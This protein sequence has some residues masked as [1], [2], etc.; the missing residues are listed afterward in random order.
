MKQDPW[1]KVEPNSSGTSEGQRE[2]KT[3]GGEIKEAAKDA[4][5]NVSND[6]KEGAKETSSVAKQAAGHAKDNGADALRSAKDA[7]KEVARTAADMGSEAKKGITEV[8]KDAVDGAS[9]IGKAATTAASDAKDGASAIT[10]ATVAAASDAAKGVGDVA[11]AV[12]DE[13]LK[14]AQQAKE[15]VTNAAQRIGPTIQRATRATGAFVASNAVPMSLLGFGAGWLFM[16]SMRSGSKAKSNL[17]PALGSESGLGSEPVLGSD[18]E[19][20]DIEIERPLQTSELE[21]SP[22]H[23]TRARL[24][25]R[26]G[27]IR[28][29]ATDLTHRAEHRIEQAGEAVGRRA[30]KLS[31]DARAQY[32]HAKGATAHL[33]KENPLM[34]LAL[35]MGA[36]M[37]TAALF[38]A[39]PAENKLMGKARDDLVGEA[40]ATASNIGDVARRSASELRDGLTSARR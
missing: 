35:S 11:V 13:A 33:F 30:S 29:R 17:A 5:K 2:I 6:L 23:P 12:Q 39:T 10:K 8:A 31:H 28:R 20:F 40:R 15:G 36:G 4:T 21:R 9:A 32:D 34:L 16:S 3:F 7:S 37:S 27:E 22:A 38:P 25:H 1:S 26:A 24:Q 18:A 14:V 19:A